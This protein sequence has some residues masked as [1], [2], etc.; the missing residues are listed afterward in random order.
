MG[1]KTCSGLCVAEGCIPF[2]TSTHGLLAS[3]ELPRAVNRQRRQALAS[4]TADV[5]VP[6]CAGHMLAYMYA[7]IYLAIYPSIYL[8]IYLYRHIV[9]TCACLL[10]ADRGIKS[11]C[12]FMSTCI[13]PSLCI[14]VCKILYPYI[15]IYTHTHG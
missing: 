6:W 5:G 1:T 9:Y 13:Y 10:Y 8:S 12:I 15:Y 14:Y 11:L 3:R 4:K 7:S 2:T